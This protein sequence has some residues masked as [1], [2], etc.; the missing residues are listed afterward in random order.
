MPYATTEEIIEAAKTLSWKGTERVKT[1]DL[2]PVLAFLRFRGLHGQRQRF[3][4][5]SFDLSRVLFDLTG[6]HLPIG[7]GSA[8]RK[9][10][11][12][13]AAG[14]A[15]RWAQFFRNGEA[16][17]NTYLNKI[18]SLVGRGPR[19]LPVFKQNPPTLPV[20]VEL[21]AGWLSVLRGS[22]AISYIFDEQPKSFVTWL[23]RY[24]VPI[25][26]DGATSTI[27]RSDDGVLRRD[28]NT[29]LSE[30]PNSLAELHQRLCDFLGLTTAQL[31]QLL[32][33]LGSVTFPIGSGASPVD[34]AGF[35]EILDAALRGP[36]NSPIVQV[37][38]EAS[39]EA[40]DYVI[41]W[42]QLTSS[43]LSNCKLVGVEAA[44]RAALAALQARKFVI[45]FGPPGTGKSELAAF[46]ANTAL[47][48][49][50]PGLST[51]TATAEWST[52][53]TMG[54]YSPDPTEPNRL[55]YTRGIISESL[56]TGA[57]LLVDEVNRADFDK[58]FGEL[59]TLFAGGK[60]Q[61]PFR[62]TDGKS[63]VLIPNEFP[64]TVDGDS[65]SPIIQQGG[66]RMMATMNSAD[67]SSLFQLSYAFMRR[68]AFV[69]VPVPPDPAFRELL[70][71]RAEELQIADTAGLRSTVLD[72]INA[73]F[74]SASGLRS[75]HPS[76]SL[77]PA[78]PLDILDF[79]AA[80]SVVATTTSEDPPPEPRAIL[81]D[82]LGLY[83]FPQLEGRETE[84]TT[85]RNMLEQALS[86]T[87]AEVSTVDRVMR[88]WT[89]ART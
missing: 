26:P 27:A 65:E 35:G 39:E 51:A 8:Q 15:A 46:I 40:T 44:L 29:S 50:S 30:L 69:E 14:Q 43:V 23:F 16:P 19:Q 37:R 25:A 80:R 54:G 82:S 6:V 83:L 5:E 2:W 20:T 3:A 28:R 59:F 47:E 84:H 81:L 10:F 38:G 7:L 86:L 87:P 85:I 34:P 61:L 13:P 52:F 58:A 68:F 79:V 22:P 89:N 63:I 41:S 76:L 4:L 72:G 55:R 78:I 9:A 57:W 24:G 49:G 74:C 73:I 88:L 71:I 48:F 45:F 70:R 75:V 36:E 67:K 56:Y 60:V 42:D 33:N 66:W 31:Q 1:T 77:G 11:F 62:D 64:G 12:D 18:Q 32:P 17:R 53:E 21:E